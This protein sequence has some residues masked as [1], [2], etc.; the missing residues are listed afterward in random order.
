MVKEAVLVVALLAMGGMTAEASTL[1]QS[2]EKSAAQERYQKVWEK[3]YGGKDDDIAYDIVPLEHGESAIVGTC[4]SFAAQSKDICVSRM[5]ADG[6]MMWTILLGGKRYDEGRAITRA[7]DGNLFVLGM[8]K[9]FSKDYDRD[10]YVAKIDLKGELLWQKSIGGTRDEQ[11]GGIAGLDDGGVMVVGDT[12]SYGKRYRDIYIAKLNKEGK[13][14]FAR[15]VGGEKRDEA[16]DI[17]RLSDGNLALVGVRV[18]RKNYEEFFVMKLDQEGKQLWAKTFGE[19]DDDSLESVTATP[20]GGMV[21]VGKTR[22][23]GSEQTDLT[24]MRLSAEGRVLWHKVYGFKY[25]EY[26]NAVTMTR[27]GGFM[28]AGGTST[29]GKGSHSV[30]MLAL[31]GNGKL[32]WSHVYGDKQRDVA[33]GI[34]RMSDGTLVS[35]GE[36][37]SYSRAKNFHMIKVRPLN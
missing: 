23:Y 24:V 15:T 13:L 7:A 11:P 26:A 34:A 25:Y 33:H 16:H 14:V 36:S 30:Y 27:D 8:T 21:A 19:Y 29:L 12:E 31:D 3:I 22:S 5:R 20:D 35:V 6:Q 37:D 32:L 10:I 9:S 17:T 18:T 28:V 4:K 1:P 2:K